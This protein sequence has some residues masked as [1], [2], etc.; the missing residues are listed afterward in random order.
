MTDWSYFQAFMAGAG[1]ARAW[2]VLRGLWQIPERRG[3]VHCGSGARLSGTAPG[4]V[5]AQSVFQPVN[6]FFTRKGVS[7]RLLRSH[8]PAERGNTKR[9]A[10]SSAL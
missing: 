9:R 2:W 4:C 8:S 7:A 6:I 5:M 3:A 1:Q 10:L